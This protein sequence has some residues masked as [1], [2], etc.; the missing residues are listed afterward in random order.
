MADYKQ[1]R[2]RRDTLTNWTG[3]VPADGEPIGI[4][5]ADGVVTT[6]KIGDGV[7][8]ADA[9]P[10]LSKGDRGD[11][12]LQG[13]PGTNGVATDAAVATNVQTDGTA[14]RAALLALIPTLNVPQLP[15][16]RT[17]AAVAAVACWGD[18]ITEIGMGT[19]SYSDLLAKLTGL[20]VYNGGKWGQSSPQIAARQGGAPALITFPSNTIPTTTSATTVTAAVNPLGGSYSG[21]RIGSIHGVPGTLAWDQPTNTLT[22]ARATAGPAVTLTGAAKFVPADGASIV[23]RE[24]AQILWAGRNGAQDVSGNVAA[25]RQMASYGNARFLVLGVLPWSGQTSPDAT[26]YAYQE[27]FPEQFRDIGAWLRTPS[28]AAAAN[29]TFTSDDQADIAARLTPRSFRQDDVHPNAAGRTA[30]AAYIFAEMQKLGWVASYVAP[31]LPVA[32]TN[33][34]DVSGRAAGQSIA[35]VDPLVGT[36]Q[37][38][39]STASAQPVSVTDALFKRNAASVNATLKISAALAAVPSVAT[40]TMIGRLTDATDANGKLIVNLLGVLL[41]VN[42]AKYGTYATSGGA[43]FTGS[44]TAD[45]L[46]HVFTVVLNGASSTLWI[47]GVNVGTGTAAPSSVQLTL[48]GGA[49]FEVLELVYND[50]VLS[51]ANIAATS[52]ALRSGYIK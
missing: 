43:A 12:G 4:I 35:A 50:S 42:G 31:A 46:P 18:S 32:A 52:A 25:I 28:A 26:N 41:R 17:P 33:R 23:N 45:T 19:D 20:P 5:G 40:V 38:T 44:A 51:D 47:D 3:I 13:L 27:A 39:Q 8:A 22:F 15:P 48:G 2:V 10:A 16:A 36:I 24:A 9:L 34:W 30:I 11:R 49:G 7:T 6:Y 37:L 21:S 14:T 1:I 29:I